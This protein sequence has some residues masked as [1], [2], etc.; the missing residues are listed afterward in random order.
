[1]R[2]DIRPFPD[3]NRGSRHFAILFSISLC[4][5]WC[6]STSAEQMQQMLGL[7]ATLNL[8]RMVND[9][10]NKNMLDML[11]AQIS[12][13]GNN[14]EGISRSSVIDSLKWAA[15]TYTLLTAPGGIAKIGYECPTNYIRQS[16]A[17]S[18]D[19]NF[20]SVVAN[21]I[22]GNRGMHI[23]MSLYVCVPPE[24]PLG[25][26]A[27]SVRVPEKMFEMKPSEYHPCT[28]STLNQKKLAHSMHQAVKS[29]L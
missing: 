5:P 3:L 28:M 14:W 17:H 8:F 16:A 29:L 9:G 19:D 21:V 4:C 10:T 24:I 1:M 23:F 7:E 12:R 26:G 11:L 2:K 13:N 27:V 25:C 15:F 6:F 22:F 20:E 18:H